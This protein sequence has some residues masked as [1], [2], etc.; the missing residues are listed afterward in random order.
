MV[1]PPTSRLSSGGRGGVSASLTAE[2]F[3]LLALGATE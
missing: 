3:S 2:A 1:I